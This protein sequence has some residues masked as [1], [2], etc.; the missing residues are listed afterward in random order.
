MSIV[1]YVHCFRIIKVKIYTPFNA[2]IK[3]NCRGTLLKKV[4]N[5]P[6]GFL[7]AWK[8]EIVFNT[9][10]FSEH[11]ACFTAKLD[12]NIKMEIKGAKN[13]KKNYGVLKKSTTKI[14]LGTDCVP[15]NC[16]NASKSASYSLYHE[17]AYFGHNWLQYNFIKSNTEICFFISL[18]FKNSLLT[19]NGFPKQK[20]DTQAAPPNQL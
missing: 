2:L 1:T 9:S 4:Y 18:Q 10:S 8:V 20:Y 13:L 7:A 16:R 15:L 3:L 17:K 14:M 5:Y 12:L 11:S 6:I 19:K